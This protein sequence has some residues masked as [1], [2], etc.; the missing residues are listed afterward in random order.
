MLIGGTVT[1][2]STMESAVSH[3][4]AYPEAFNKVREEID[5]N[6][7]QFRLLDE[8]DLPK[9]SFLHCIIS[10]TIRLGSTGP[11]IPPHESSEKCTVGG[12]DIPRGTMFLVNTLTL[13]RDPKLWED[14]DLFKP[15]RFQV[16][17]VEK[18][19]SKFIPF[20]LGRRQCPGAGLAMRVMALSLGTLIQCFDLHNADLNG[21]KDGPVRV[22]FRPRE[23][24]ASALCQH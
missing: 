20:G 11:I 18:G 12:Y 2:K 10:E 22:I 3:L 7:D 17:E 13:Y 8:S 16:N 9:L 19:A 14:P 6:I 21:P 23:G 24:L 5:N 1:S 4:I 15:G